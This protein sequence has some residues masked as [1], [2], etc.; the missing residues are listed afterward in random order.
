MYD[1]FP[2]RSAKPVCMLR[3]QG[4]LCGKCGTVTMYAYGMNIQHD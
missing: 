1:M 3:M 4:S 2:C